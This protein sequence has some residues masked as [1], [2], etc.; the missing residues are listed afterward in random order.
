MS[1]YGQTI[2]WKKVFQFYETEKERHFGNGEEVKVTW[3]LKEYRLT[4]KMKKNKVVCVIKYKVKC[5]PRITKDTEKKKEDVRRRR[6][7]CETNW[8]A[9]DFY[10]WFHDRS[11][12]TWS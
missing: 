6:G 4:R 7:S 5:L 11:S 3:T 8:N 12:R 10:S 2:G 9:R 1:R